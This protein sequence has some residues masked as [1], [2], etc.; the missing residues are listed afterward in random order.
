MGAE[1]EASRQR[2]RVE[3]PWDSQSQVCRGRCMSEPRPEGCPGWRQVLGIHV[4]RGCVILAE[5]T[6]RG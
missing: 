1:R 3:T 4:D 5:P 2:A 6:G